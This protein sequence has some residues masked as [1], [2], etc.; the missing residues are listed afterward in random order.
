MIHKVKCVLPLLQS[1]HSYPRHLEVGGEHIRHCEQAHQR[2]EEN[3]RT[4][5]LLV[6]V[7]ALLVFL[8]YLAVGLVD[9]FDLHRSSPFGDF[10]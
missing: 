8:D 4:L 2:A 9:N 1:V 6:L 3:V 7:V 5:R 10:T